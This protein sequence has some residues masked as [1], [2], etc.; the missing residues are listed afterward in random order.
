[1][2]PYYFKLFDQ[3]DNK[4]VIERALE[5]IIEVAEDFGPAAFN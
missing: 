5:N 2:I 4:E 1:M 3:E